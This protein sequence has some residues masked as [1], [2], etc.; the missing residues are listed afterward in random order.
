MN[1][2]R[3]DF[4][5]PCLEAQA[6]AVYDGGHWYS[7]A[8]FNN[9]QSAKPRPRVPTPLERAQAI[10]AEVCARRFPVRKLAV[11]LPDA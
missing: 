1:N 11:P 5:F 9:M 2:D 3:N 10:A 6:A 4:G 8:Q 7:V